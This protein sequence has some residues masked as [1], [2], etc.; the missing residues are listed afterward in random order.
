ML[1]RIVPFCTPP[2]LVCFSVANIL[3]LPKD[4][5]VS[6]QAFPSK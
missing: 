3:A 4:I 1:F 2:N 5:L 6:V